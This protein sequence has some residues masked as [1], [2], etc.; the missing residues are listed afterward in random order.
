MAFVGLETGERPGRRLDGLVSRA[1]GRGALD[2][3]D[4]RMLL[5]LVVAELLTRVEA[6]ED[7]PR[8]VLAAEDDRGA[9]A[10]RRLDLGEPPRLHDDPQSS[11][12]W[13]RVAAAGRLAERQ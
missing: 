10:A 7:G 6:D 8:L 3:D 4:P 12:G 9:A 1:E 2:D 11:G 5:D 13:E